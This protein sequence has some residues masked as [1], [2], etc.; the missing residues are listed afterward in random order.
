MKKLLNRYV[1]GKFNL[2]T[3][4]LVSAVAFPPW[5][6]LFSYSSR[7]VSSRYL[8]SLQIE[9]IIYVMNAMTYRCRI[10]SVVH[11]YQRN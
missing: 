2:F 4:K 3:A 10:I 1:I 11:I 9:Q 7:S 8:N 5:Q 6:S